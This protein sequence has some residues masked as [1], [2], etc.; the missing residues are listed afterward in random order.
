MG[1]LGLG[2]GRGLVK[3]FYNM[4]DEIP[5]IGCIPSIPL[6]ASQIL[7]AKIVN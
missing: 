3:S 1:I 5:D 2:H 7:L 6:K 4:L